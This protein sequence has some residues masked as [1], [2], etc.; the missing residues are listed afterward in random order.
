MNRLNRYF[1]LVFWV[2][3]IFPA[4]A[5]TLPPGFVETLLAQ[6][7]DPTD[8]V[9]APDGR[10]FITIKS[11]KI[12]IVE[13]NVLLSTL[14][15]D[16]PVDNTNER[17]LGHMVLD[18]HF[19]M[20]HYYYV[21]YTVPGQNLNRISRFTANGNSTI[22]GSEVILLNLN[23]MAG[24]I[25]NAGSMAFGA[26]E[27]LY[28]GVG[29]GADANTSQSM[30]TLLGKILRINTDPTNLIP[31]DNPFFTSASGNNRAIYAL[32][33]RNPFSMDIQPGTGRIFVGDVGG[34]QW[35]EINDILPGKNYGW[36]LIEGKRTNQTAPANYQDPLFAYS[37]SD[38]CAI[39]G[40]AFYNPTLQ[41]FP[42]S[43][44]GKFFYADYCNQYIRVLDPAT[45][46]TS[47]FATN[48]NRA[49]AI[50]VAADG[51]LY[52]LA[53][54]GL[55]GGSEGDN[56]SSSNGSLW[57]VN[58]TGSGAPF[59]SVNPASQIL[60][61]G[62]IARFE[63]LASG[64]A[65]L[66]YQ[67]QVDGND[68]AGATTSVFVTNNV[69]LGDNQKKFRCRITNS[70]G[71]VTSIEATLTVTSNTRPIVNITLPVTG[72]TYRAG[73]LILFSGSATDAESG[74]LSTAQLSWKIDFHHGAHTHPAMA[75]TAE[76]TSGSYSV[77]RIGETASNVFYRVYLTATDT[78]AMHPL[79]QTT[80]VDVLPELSN[81]TLQTEPA[82]LT[83]LLDGQ[84]IE[85]PTIVSSVVGITR[86]LE[87]PSVQTNIA[88]SYLYQAW[89]QPGLARQFNFNVDATPTTYS[90]AFNILPVGDGNGLAGFYHNSED[91]IFDESP[92]LVRI[93][94]TINFNW[95]GGS[96]GTSINNDNFV[97]RWQ[98]EVLAPVSGSYTFTTRTDD[99]VRLWVN[100]VLIIN[101]W[102]PQAATDWTGTI[103]LTA[104]TK[105]PLVME[106]YE[107]SGNA[108]A[109]LLWSY[110]GIPK[111]IIPTT[112]LYTDVITR[113]IET[114]KLE[115]FPTIVFTEI[116]I[117]SDLPWV[118]YNSMG[119]PLR[120]NNS[121]S[122]D[123]IEVS[124]WANGWYFVRA[125]NGA[126][127]KF[128][129]Y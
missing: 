22:A 24:T 40:A 56:T 87:A 109:R 88:G 104:E 108:E 79:S 69:A 83:L 4:K 46:S 55:G 52:Y 70:Q 71:T 13:N 35:E 86:T 7:L 78:D 37:H 124:G 10:V 117:H 62:E 63:V 31:S 93:D 90:A 12:L 23:V 60:P 54:A 6:N 116:E 123:R 17:G 127:K 101:Q 99:G 128:V 81:L 67:W 42:T 59:I 36:P 92:D 2:V 64:L 26:D 72:T 41:Q 61:V 68:I 20:N 49:V 115:V 114:T 65:P 53:R 113:V 122:K 57:K 95:G 100:D 38:G 105:Y 98:G 28:V 48:I 45:G 103:A 19:E 121:Q 47:G 50:R 29:D 77:P 51:S 5:A 96:P 32:G 89:S 33:F 34:S 85:T 110:E 73:E 106:F 3:S 74:I 118:I 66:S 84:P 11:G 58:Y 97:V 9:L 21:Y 75:P 91:Q 129:K 30:N 43:F 27:K 80:Y 18:P 15:L 44:V 39:V 125:S 102:I 8:I 112:Q 107:M 119:Q 14:F 16:L 94:P 76:L 126:V 120:R 82:G 1:I 111:Q 25:H